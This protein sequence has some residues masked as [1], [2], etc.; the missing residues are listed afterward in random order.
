MLF[1][2][3][4]LGQVAKLKQDLEHL[5]G[6]PFLHCLQKVSELETL[7]ITVLKQIQQQMRVDLETIEKVSF[8]KCCNAVRFFEVL[9]CCEYYNI[10]EEGHIL[11]HQL[12]FP[13]SIEIIIHFR[14]FAIKSKKDLKNRFLISC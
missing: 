2:F 13:T 11:L 12:C 9:V 7:P 8:G 1:L 10:S 4:A 5:R 14:L 6:G 3:Q